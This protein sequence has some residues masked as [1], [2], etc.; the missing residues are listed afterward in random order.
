MKKLCIVL[1]F[2]PPNYGPSMY[3]A[4]MIQ[5]LNDIEDIEYLKINAEI[6]TSSHK[7]GKYSILKFFKFI[8]VIFNVNK[9]SKNSN[10]ILNLHLSLGG[11]LKT[12]VLILLNYYKI[13][14]LTL[15]LHEG[16]LKESLNNSFVKR[17]LIRYSVNKSDVIFALDEDQKVLGL[18]YTRMQIL[19][20]YQH[21]EMNNLHCLRKQNELFFLPT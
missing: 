6:N 15:I 13:K 18:T 11:S 16:G 10:L 7:I 1:P 17:I 20:L 5:A 19:K 14:T 21:I 4:H 12:F 8:K 3:S 9:E 2:P